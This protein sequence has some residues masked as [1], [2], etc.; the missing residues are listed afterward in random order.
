MKEFVKVSIFLLKNNYICWIHMSCRKLLLMNCMIRCL[1]SGKPPMCS[2][3]FKKF[4]YKIKKNSN[5]G[6]NRSG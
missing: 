1:A 5:I 3:L 4:G 2:F 6:G